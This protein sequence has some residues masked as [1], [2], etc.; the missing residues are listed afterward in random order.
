VFVVGQPTFRKLC[1]QSSS[2]YFPLFA[3]TGPLQKMQFIGCTMSKNEKDRPEPD[4]Q[5]VVRENVSSRR[6]LNIYITWHVLSQN[7]RS[8][9]GLGC[10][11][12]PKFSEL[13]TLIEHLYITA[14]AFAK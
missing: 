14:P 7:E 9:N 4:F 8:A 11:G 3:P 10:H 2:S 5:P 12:A 6:S 13:Q 1:D